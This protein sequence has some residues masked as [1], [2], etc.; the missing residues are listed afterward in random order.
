MYFGEGLACL[1]PLLNISIALPVNLG[2]ASDIGIPLIDLLL[3]FLASNAVPFLYFSDQLIA[4]TVENV[5][6]II[7]QFTPTLL[8]RPFQLLPLALHLVRVHFLRSLSAALSSRQMEF[9]SQAWLTC[10]TQIPINFRVVRARLTGRRDILGAGRLQD[11]LGPFLPLGVLA[12]DRDQDPT[13]FNSAFVALSF[14]F[15]DAH[16][17]QRSGDAA[18][19]TSH[20]SSSERSHNR[21]G[22]DKWPQSRNSE[23]ADAHQPSHGP[24]EDNT[25]AGPCRGSLRSLRAF[26]VRKIL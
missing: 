11:L 19:R 3:S 16:S 20:S 24:A 15:R 9:R 17:Y 21:T 8:Y 22:G 25:G 23:C 6:I 13:I 5:D 4:L 18:D 10:S 14:V 1:P 26:L 2:F 12:M 7:G